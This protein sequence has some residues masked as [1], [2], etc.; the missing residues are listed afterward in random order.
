[1]TEA[2]KATNIAPEATAPTAFLGSRRA[3]KGLARK[4]TKG[5]R[6]I[7]RRNGGGPAEGIDEETDEGKERNPEKH[8]RLP[9]QLPERVRIER[10]DVP[11]ER[12]HD[13]EAH[14]R[15]GCGHSDDEEHDD[16]SVGRSQ[17]TAEGDEREI[18]RVEHH[19][20][21]QQDGNHV[22]PE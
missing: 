18:D 17:E 16:L 2:R 20:D 9:S 1:I 12:N 13:G 10:L 14:S 6:G 22:S 8:R 5:R 21:R 15:L 19:L 7:Q 11:E 4:P 3:P